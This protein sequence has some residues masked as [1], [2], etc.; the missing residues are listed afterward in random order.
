MRLK[1]TVAPVRG[2]QSTDR[3]TSQPASQPA[4]ATDTGIDTSFI[5][6]QSQGD[7]AKV[8]WM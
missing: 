3:K 8:V 5:I 1:T 7:M 4:T 2:M 6:K